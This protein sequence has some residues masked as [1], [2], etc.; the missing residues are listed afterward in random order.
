MKSIHGVSALLAVVAPL[1]KAGPAPVSIGWNTQESFGPDGPWQGVQVSIGTSDDAEFNTGSTVTLYPGGEW[2]SQILT[3]AF[4][5][6]TTSGCFADQAG[7]YNNTQSISAEY[8]VQLVPSL[9]QWGSDS[10]L[11]I[12][13]ER[14]IIIDR[15]TWQTD[16]SYAVP[17]FVFG[18][19]N[20]SNARLPNGN[21]YSTQVGS[22]ALGAPDQ[23][24]HFGEQDGSSITGNLI[25]GYL[26]NQSIIPSSSWG[27]HIGSVPQKISGSLN[28]GGFDQSRAL[29]KVGSFDLDGG[30]TPKVQLIGIE[31]G[32]ITGGTPFNTTDITGLYQFDG[33]TSAPTILNPALPYLFLPQA[34]CDAIAAYLPVTYQASVGLYTW[35]I[36][37]PNYVTIVSSPAYLGF[38]FALPGGTNMTI[39]VPFPLLNL[40]LEAPILNQPQAYFPCKPYYT[41]DGSYHLGRAFLQA[42]FLGI[43]WDS[44]K[45]FVAQAPGPNTGPS[46]ITA[47]HSS[48]TTIGSNTIDTYKGSWSAAWTPLPSPSSS[49][50]STNS[51]SAPESSGQ[52]VS[53]NS[54]SSSGLSDS[55]KI[56]IGV[57][58]GIVVVLLIAG[59]AACLLLRNK[60]K[61]RNAAAAANDDSLT[62]EQRQIQY[63]D[64]KQ[65]YP[66]RQQHSGG[67]EY[68]QPYKDQTQ[69][70]GS[71]W[72]QVHELDAPMVVHETGDGSL[73]EMPA[74]SAR[75]SRGVSAGTGTTPLTSPSR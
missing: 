60:K 37:D 52:P 24:Q 17:N 53:Q 46:Q 47:I 34:T 31:M 67:G 42:A 11:N 48:D 75:R 74:D 18:A 8:D 68:Y 43:N 35:N 14:S 51:S 6:G 63:L 38:T 20:S 40:T 27:L 71:P 4:C 41:P 19:V 62:P 64:G 25:T 33:N 5:N 10:V 55:A 66:A 70:R 65:R 36:D 12:T 21:Y 69:G 59:I 13:G 2:D 39:Q 58:I 49:S 29:G 32:A 50:P 1:I 3:G 23:S 7:L 30:N 57:G 22:L 15:I 72:R 44:R 26:S 54:S 45:F 9:G 61:R 28:L 16:T 56:G 73:P